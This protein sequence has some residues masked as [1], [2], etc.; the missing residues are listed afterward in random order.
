MIM[1]RIPALAGL[2][3]A[4]KFILVSELWD[5]IAAHPERIPLSEEQLA[6]MDRRMETYRANPEDVTT[7]EEIQARL[8]ESIR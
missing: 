7:W 5:D 8:K 2:T 4:E 1:E 3:T 6:E